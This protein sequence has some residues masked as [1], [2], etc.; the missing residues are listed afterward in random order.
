[1]RRIGLLYALIVLVAL[2]VGAHGSDPAAEPSGERSITLATTTS[3]QDSG[4][5]DELLPVF[6]ADAG[7]G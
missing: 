1:M 3:T 4:L 5:L 6:I 2:L 7:R